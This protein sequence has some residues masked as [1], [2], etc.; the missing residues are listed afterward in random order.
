MVNIE[1]I[2]KWLISKENK[3]VNY[4]MCI[5]VVRDYITS[6]HVNYKIKSI[7]PAYKHIN[8]LDTNCDY[9]CDVETSF[10]TYDDN[11]K[12]I[13]ETHYNING[14]YVDREVVAQKILNIINKY[15]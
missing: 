6:D 12:A 13:Y 9:V 10:F 15:I 8:S 5:A 4:N 3:I 1:S 2:T 7:K 11:D 14:E